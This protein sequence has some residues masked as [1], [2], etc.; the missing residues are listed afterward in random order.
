MDSNLTL[1]IGLRGQIDVQAQ[2]V[3]M[4][5]GYLKLGGIADPEAAAPLAFGVVVSANPDTDDI[6]VAG[7][8]DGNVIRGICVF[9]DAI[10]ANA[11]AHPTS[12][13]P[14]LPCA[15]INH[16][17]LYM[18]AWNKTATGAIDPVIGCKVIYNTTTGVVEFLEGAA[19]EAP[20]GWA[21]LGNADVREIDDANGAL[22]YLN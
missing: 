4:Q 2:A 21:I 10:A 22:I 6:F 14:G 12:Y 1:E 13:L 20:E 17:F 11:L 8:P 18:G 15:A 3:P 5:E 19:T 9:D 7:V 16:G